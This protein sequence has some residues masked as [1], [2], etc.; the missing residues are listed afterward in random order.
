MNAELSGLYI[1]QLLT[2][3]AHRHM[4][5][6]EL[7]LIPASPDMDAVTEI[8]HQDVYKLPEHFHTVLDIGA[9]KGIF[10]VFC[11][12]RGAEV[13][14]YEPHP[15]SYQTLSQN[16]AQNSLADRVHLHPLAVW[17]S[18]RTLQLHDTPGQNRGSCSVYHD[19]G[20]VCNNALCDDTYTV[21][22]EDFDAIIH[23]LPAW[24]VVKMDCEGAEFDILLS[25]TPA[26][27]RKIRYLTMEVHHGRFGDI[28]YHSL[29]RKLEKFFIID[30]QDN[31][32]C[33]KYDYIYARAK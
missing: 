25:A 8:W 13:Q 6:A 17:S 9:H 4:I 32:G 15:R 24:D 27:L 29:I 16:I 10:S 28:A 11:A 14:A 20:V 26:A 12:L 23:N 1:E 5:S 2:V 33:G 21:V 30:G 3:F 7:W 22:G 31:T 18:P 19:N